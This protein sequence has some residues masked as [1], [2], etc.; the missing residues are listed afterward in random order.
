MKTIMSRTMFSIFLKQ[1]LFKCRLW[2]TRAVFH[3]CR[4]LVPSPLGGYLQIPQRPSRC[5]RLPGP[6]VSVMENWKARITRASY[7]QLLCPKK[8]GMT[9]SKLGTWPIRIKISTVFLDSWQWKNVLNYWVLGSDTCSETKPFELDLANHSHRPQRIRKN[10]LSKQKP[11]SWKSLKLLDPLQKLGDFQVSHP[12]FSTSHGC[13]VP[14][15]QQQGKRCRPNLSLWLGLS[16]DSAA[17]PGA[18]FFLGQRS[19]ALLLDQHD[20][21]SPETCIFGKA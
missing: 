4:H 3:S 18:H 10:K 16:L 21:S 13:W 12:L 9:S 19:T 20:I 5:G 1:R 7:L 8:S 2:L 14:Y 17:T 11:H 6:A 15:I